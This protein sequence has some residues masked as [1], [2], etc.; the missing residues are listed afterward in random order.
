MDERQNC[1]NRI[2][3]YEKGK[4]GEMDTA[5]IELAPYCSWVVGDVLGRIQGCH[6]SGS[7]VDPTMGGI[8]PT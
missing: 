5:R 3:G 1:E 2:F 7:G 6:R 8:N 4:K